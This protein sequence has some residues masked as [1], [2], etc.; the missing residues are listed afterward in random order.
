MATWPAT[1]SSCLVLG[2]ERLNSSGGS[3][4]SYK[5]SIDAQSSGLLWQAITG[6]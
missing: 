5:D 4:I 6:P 3:E 1:P 2:A